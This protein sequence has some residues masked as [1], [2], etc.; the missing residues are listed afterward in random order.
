[1][2]ATEEKFTT[3]NH[4]YIQ[5]QKVDSKIDSTYLIVHFKTLKDTFSTYSVK[6]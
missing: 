5:L 1:M 6:T 2:S 4:Q 3:A